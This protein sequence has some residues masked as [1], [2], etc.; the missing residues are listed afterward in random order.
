[1]LRAR[2]A[3]NI[4]LASVERSSPRERLSALPLL[5]PQLRRAH[6]GQGCPGLGYAFA[7]FLYTKQHRLEGMKATQKLIGIESIN[8]EHSSAGTGFI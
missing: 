6:P 4:Y 1:M 3:Y 7:S 2:A 8:K 5:M